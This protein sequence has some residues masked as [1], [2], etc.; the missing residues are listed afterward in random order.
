MLR[1]DGIVATGGHEDVVKA[2]L[3]FGSGLVADLM[4]SRINPVLSRELSM[5]TTEAMVSV[6]FNAKTVG[7]VAASEEVAAG[8]FVADSVPIGERGIAKDLFFQG[9]RLRVAQ[10][11]FL[12]ARTIFQGGRRCVAPKQF[13]NIQLHTVTYIPNIM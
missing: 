10:E 8:S 1:P 9:G 3:T 4:A 11:T 13:N 6:D 12:S 7:V 2:R 5:W